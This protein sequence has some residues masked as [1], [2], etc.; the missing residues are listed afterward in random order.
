MKLKFGNGNSG[1]GTY[2]WLWVRLVVVSVAFAYLYIKYLDALIQPVLNVTGMAD[3]I[4]AA[5]RNVPSLVA[6]ITIATP[7]KLVVGVLLWWRVVKTIVILGSPFAFGVKMGDGREDNGETGRLVTFGKIGDS[8]V[9]GA[10]YSGKFWFGVVA[11][12]HPNSDKLLRKRLE[13]LV[14]AMPW[15]TSFLVHESHFMF[16]KHDHGSRA[17]AFRLVADRYAKTI[18]NISE[19]A[20]RRRL[21][22]AVEHH[23]PSRH[24]DGLTWTFHIDGTGKIQDEFSYEISFERIG[25]EQYKV[26]TEGQEIIVDSVDELRKVAKRITS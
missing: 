4:A 13:F 6:G 8:N 18:E 16:R 24:I 14:M 3:E 15:D 7:L 11:R 10:S 9:Y 12:S 20:F 17:K 26:K 25:K 23:A 19:D 5:T 21:L 1:M 22:A 2:I